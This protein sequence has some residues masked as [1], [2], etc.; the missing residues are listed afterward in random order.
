MW[1][2][3]SEEQS[4]KETFKEF[5]SCNSMKKYQEGVACGLTVKSVLIPQHLSYAHCFTCIILYSTSYH[6]SPTRNHCVIL[7]THMLTHQ[8]Y[9]YKIERSRNT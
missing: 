2:L 7:G 9:R 1:S 8:M 4:Y 6:P 5:F 3:F